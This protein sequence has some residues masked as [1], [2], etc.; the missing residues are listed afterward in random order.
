MASVLCRIYLWPSTI[1]PAFGSVINYSDSQV[2]P[3]RDRRNPTSQA[4][5]FP[6]QPDLDGT[7]DMYCFA[8]MHQPSEHQRSRWLLNRINQKSSQVAIYKR[9]LYEAACY[10]CQIYEQAFIACQVVSFKCYTVLWTQSLQLFFYQ[11]WSNPLNP[12]KRCP[13][14]T[15]THVLLHDRAPVK[16]AASA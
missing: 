1:T 9:L 15:H 4:V 3:Q 10:T 5:V 11:S 8:H 6:K 14:C 16:E 2:C 13:M 12:G 7:W